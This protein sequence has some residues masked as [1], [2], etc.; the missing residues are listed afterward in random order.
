MRDRIARWRDE[1]GDTYV[2]GVV[3]VAFGV[4]LF[5]NALRAARELQDGYFGDVF[6]W[7]LF[8]ESFVP[9]RSVYGTIVA[10][11]VLLSALVVAGHRARGALF[12]SA[13]LGAYVLFCDRLQFHHNRWA[14]FCYAFLLSFAPCDRSFTVGTV[15]PATRVGPMWAARL[16][17]LQVSIIYVASG[18][19]KLLDP[20]WRGGRVVYERIAL[21]GQNAIDAGVP[22]WFMHWLAQT[23]T[24][25]MLA[26][27]A[28]ATELALAFGLWSRH[29]RILCLWWGL[30][31]H[32]TIEGTSRVEGFTWL[33]LAAYAL[34]CTPDVGARKLYYDKRRFRGRAYAHA[35]ALLDWFARFE[36]R[37]WTPDGIERGHTIVVIRRDG[38]H[39]TGIHALAVVVRCTPLL[40][41]LWGPLALAATFAKPPLSR[42]EP[43]D[44]VV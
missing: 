37:P 2:L 23:D 16:A 26:K 36:I 21:Y 31:F 6:H 20:D 25:S 17:A 38:V 41:P 3:R 10:V 8:P 29:A 39:V 34:F 15:L 1:L 27:M 13:V 12:A 42:D 7:P 32:L 11:Q 28:I 40:F 19:S 44:G 33:T 24:T 4:L 35:V 30:W 18:G 43:D 22:G 9:S 5:A 14:L